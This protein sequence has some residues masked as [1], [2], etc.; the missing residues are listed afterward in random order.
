MKIWW[1][2]KQM[3]LMVKKSADGLT[4]LDGQTQVLMM[5]SLSLNSMQKSDMTNQKDQLRPIMVKLTPL[6]FIEKLMSQM[7]KKSAD[8]PTPWDGPIPETM[9]RVS[10]E[11]NEME[12][13]SH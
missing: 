1:E 2:E 5:T 3:L 6:S 10:S 11:R 9:M 13:N 4:H 12:I 8:G 7:E